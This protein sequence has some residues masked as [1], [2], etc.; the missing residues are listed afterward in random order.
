MMK[1]QL[2]VSTCIMALGLSVAHAGHHHGKG[3][4]MKFFDANNDG[5][6]SMAEFEQ[7]SAARFGKIDTDGNGSLSQDEFKNYVKQRRSERRQKHFNKADANNDG[8]V[9]KAEYL[10][11]KRKRAEKRFAR[12]DKDGDGNITNEEFASAK[13]HKHGK[14]KSKKIFSRMDKN[15]DGIVS[16]E[17]SHT[18][19]SNW[20]S[21]LDGNKDSV[22]TAEEIRQAREQRHKRYHQGQ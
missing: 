17:E 14:G 4:F 15:N 1:K 22:V 12:M 7:A 10:E 5:S 8:Q 16:R 19:W 6:V 13:K 18:A 21:R 9:S 2:L 20:F 11:A 3:K